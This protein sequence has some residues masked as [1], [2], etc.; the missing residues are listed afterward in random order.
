MCGKRARPDLACV[1]GSAHRR[2]FLDGCRQ[3]GV[4]RCGPGEPIRRTG[5]ACMLPHA[6]R[7]DG[8]KPTH[9]T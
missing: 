4:R 2:P 5:L 1:T 8:A 9:R 7:S 6:I 3:S